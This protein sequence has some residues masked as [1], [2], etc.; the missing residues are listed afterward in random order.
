MIDTEP[1][2]ASTVETGCVDEM[3]PAIFPN[4]TD[5]VGEAAV[6]TGLAGDAVRRKSVSFV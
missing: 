6:E 5:F 2:M 1:E 3:W 4:M